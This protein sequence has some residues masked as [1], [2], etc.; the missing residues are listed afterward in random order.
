[1]DEGN[2][3]EAEAILAHA[4]PRIPDVSLWSFYIDYVRQTRLEPAL[5]AAQASTSNHDSAAKRTTKE[6]ME[7]R[8]EVTAAYDFAVQRLGMCRGA[9]PL[10]EGYLQH[11]AA[12]PGEDDHQIAMNAVALRKVYRQAVISPLSNGTELWTRYRQWEEEQGP[13]A[14]SASELAALDA[15]RGNAQVVA[16]RREELWSGIV[17]STLARPPPEARQGPT[18]PSA[19]Q[20]G[21]HLRKQLVKWQ[22]LLLYELSN[23]LHLPAEAFHAQAR[24]TFEQALLCMSGFPDLWQQYAML[25]ASHGEPAAAMAVYHRG[26]A[27]N[28]NCSTLT[29]AAADYMESV[30]EGRAAVEVLEALVERSPGTL[31]YILLMRSTRRVLGMRAA[32]AVFATAR[33]GDCATPELFLAA[34]ALERDANGDAESAA[35]VLK[36]AHRKFQTD[37]DFAVAYVDMMV[38]MADDSNVRALFENILNIL[39][40]DVAR[41]VWDR[42]VAFELR[43]CRAGGSVAT[44]AR[45]ERRRAEMYPADKAAFPNPLL[46]LMHRYQHFGLQPDCPGDVELTQRHP[47]TPY[48][49]HTKHDTLVPSDKRQAQYTASKTASTLPAIPGFSIV[50]TA[51][52]PGS[53]GVLRGNGATATLAVPAGS[54]DW[55]VDLLEVLPQPK[56]A[57]TTADE[58]VECIMRALL[59]APLPEKPPVAHRVLKPARPSHSTPAIPMAMPPGAFPRGAPP[60]PMGMAPPMHGQPRQG[61]WGPG[62]MQP[63]PQHHQRPP[64]GPGQPFHQRGP[65]G[66]GYGQP[67]HGRAPMPPQHQHQHHPQGGHRQP[68]PQGFPPPRGMPGGLVIQDTAAQ[69]PPAMGGQRRQ[70]PPGHHP[71]SHQMPPSKH[72][73]GGGYQRR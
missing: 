29:F 5:A 43:R 63:P 66:P 71:P 36:A 19:A 22:A 23:P 61:Q 49:T 24:L 67:P 64:Q 25:E 40:H 44:L 37:A 9:E 17:P 14:A 45:V 1:M 52:A 58:E 69:G 15:P 10:W 39:P 13:S 8:E 42:Y 59:T 3:Q 34:A 31:A 55:V 62:H 73:R 51:A 33:G 46:A 65:P 16:G 47:F 21:E 38:G 32:R 54:P 72:A 53:G 50:D 11:L 12:A 6:V 20:A 68:P 57:H 26:I 48:L 60:P 28:P 41:P 70:R 30:G 35:R 4:L 7:A 2:L 56:P 18:P 27:A